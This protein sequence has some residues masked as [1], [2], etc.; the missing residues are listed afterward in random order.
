MK[1]SIVSYFHVKHILLFK[2]FG[3]KNTEDYIE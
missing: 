3:E 2:N 1:K